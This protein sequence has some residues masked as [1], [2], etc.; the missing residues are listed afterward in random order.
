MDMQK[1]LIV[2]DDISLGFLL[3]E[4]LESEGFEVKLARDGKTGWSYFQK[5]KFDLCI[6]D[7]M[8]PVVDGFTLARKIRKISPKMPFF[9][10]TAKTLKADKLEGFSIGA[11]DYITKPFDEEVLLCRINVILRREAALS[12]KECQPTRFQLGKYHFDAA[13]QELTF[14]NTTKRITEKENE[15]LHLLCLNRNK[16]L[17]RDEAVEKIYGKKDYFLGRSFDVFVSKLRKLLSKD[18]RIQIENV[19]RVGFILKVE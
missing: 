7:V 10:L 2:E 16:I 15:V 6:F 8:M 17:R 13:L 9:F 19:F 4:F 12:P 3:M 1:I 11:E 18:E 5:N 14:D